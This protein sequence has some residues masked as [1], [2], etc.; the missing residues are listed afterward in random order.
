MRCSHKLNLSRR[1]FSGSD[2]ISHY[3]KIK[4]S[5]SDTRQNLTKITKY[6][7]LILTCSG[8]CKLNKER[9]NPATMMMILGKN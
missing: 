1:Q 2:N 8:S 3:A 9:M 7:L 5:P 4:Y 6:L